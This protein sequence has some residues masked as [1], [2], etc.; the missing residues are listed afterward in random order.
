MHAERAQRVQLVEALHTLRHDRAAEGGEHAHQSA[1]RHPAVGV[2][3]ASR[4]T[5]VIALT[6]V[7]FF[8][9]LLT[10][11]YRMVKMFVSGIL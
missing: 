9:Y 11:F 7:V 4:N 6:L 8:K 10:S 5:V 3:R 1:E 2:G